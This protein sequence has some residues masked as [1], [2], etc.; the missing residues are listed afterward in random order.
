ML[1]QI[2]NQSYSK[3]IKL[4]AIH[5]YLNG[6]G[7]QN[8]ICKKYGIRSRTQLRRW[9][10]VYNTGGTLKETTGGASMKKAKTTTPE[11][12]LI[13]V[14]DC[15]DNDKNYGA[16]ALKYNCSYQQ[17]RNWVV[18]YEKMGAAG[19][20]DRRG[21]RIGSQSSRTPEEELRNKVAELERKNKD[22][23]MEFYTT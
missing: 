16:M 2:H 7:S 17:V 4:Q 21:R 6:N 5:D 15:L 19:L 8:D 10:K 20:E 11:E 1:N 3:D 18:R 12:R 22:L 13:I 14:K 23:Q 9:I